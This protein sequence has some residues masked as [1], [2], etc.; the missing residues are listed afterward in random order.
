MGSV[1][2]VIQLS[3]F[4]ALFA[5]KTI[6]AALPPQESSFPETT[7]EM[8]EQVC[9]VGGFIYQTMEDIM[10]VPVDEQTFENTLGLW[11]RSSSK[12]SQ[13]LNM[14]HKLIEFKSP[15]ASLAHQSSNDLCALS[16]DAYHNPTLY[17]ILLDCSTKAFDDSSLNPLQQH[18]AKCFIENDFG[19]PLH[20]QGKMLKKHNDSKRFT[21]LNLEDLS[22]L[23]NC[24]PNVL[25]DVYLSDADIVCI[26]GVFNEDAA[27]QAYEI[28]Q[29]N[30]AH[31][32]YLN[33][34]I[35]SLKTLQE[36]S[37]GSLLIASKYAL[38][39]NEI[40]TPERFFSFF[41]RSGT[42]SLAHCYV[43]YANISS[44][45]KFLQMLQKMQN[46]TF[47]T[48]SQMPILFFGMT[49][50]RLQ[51]LTNHCCLYHP[52]KSSLGLYHFPSL[53]DEKAPQ[54]T[55]ISSFESS[56]GKLTTIEIEYFSEN[57][58]Q[59]L[60]GSSLEHYDLILCGGSV[61]VSASKDSDGNKSVEASVSTSTST[62][63]G[64]SVSVEVSGGVSQDSSG[65]TTSR[66]E[67]TA[68]FKF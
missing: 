34:D 4:I 19:V 51:I 36:S 30:Y 58:F 33:S 43:S 20:I 61:E 60:K 35:S 48:M 50:K 44:D 55:Y 37:V 11:F 64:N 6:Y 21:I 28:L 2:Y 9:D 68:T 16:L 3:V 52:S 5:S 10:S 49:S 41:I 26:N 31:F 22:S 27:Y 62:D 8:R 23:K 24:D 39:I 13:T 53:D 67:A 14:L 66:V 40:N 57:P 1:Q 56:Y 29:Q 47:L 7:W 42:S 38:E 18:L 46:D 63:N 65:N 15:L 45:S 17:Q 12:L 54:S 59:M 25:W 32:I